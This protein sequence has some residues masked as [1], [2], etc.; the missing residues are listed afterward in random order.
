MKKTY[1]TAQGQ[2]IDFDAIRLANEDAIAVGNMR[3]NARGDQL[4]PGGVVVKPRNQLMDEYYQIEA[5]PIET[6]LEHQNQGVTVDE[7]PVP[8]KPKSKKASTKAKK[9]E[10]AEADALDQV[11]QDYETAAVEA[12]AQ[13]SAELVATETQESEE[14]TTRPL[15]G[16]LADSVAKEAQVNQTLLK[17]LNKRNGV[18]RI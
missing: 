17:P 3:V 2:T 5:D 8:K 13:E 9:S 4:G 18:Q 10:V 16:N 15:R 14:A 6:I 7:T 12:Q 1:K 11:Q